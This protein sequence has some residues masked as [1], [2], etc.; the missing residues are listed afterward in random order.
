MP[1][2]LGSLGYVLSFWL[3]IQPIHRHVYSETQHYQDYTSYLSAIEIAMTQDLDFLDGTIFS[4]TEFVLITGKITNH[5][6]PD[7]PVYGEALDIP[8]YVRVRQ[9]YRGY[10][11][12]HAYVYRWD[13]DGYHSMD[14]DSIEFKLFRQKWFRQLCFDHRLMR[15]SRLRAI[16][17]PFI[18]GMKDGNDQIK[19]DVGDFMIPRSRSNQFYDWYDRE[20]GLYPLYIC[21]I[22]FTRP[23]PFIQCDPNAIDFG[24][25]YGVTQNKLP[26]ETLLRKC[27][28]ETYRLQ[29][30]MLKYISIYR[31]SD[32]FWSFYPPQLK[33][34]Y[35]ACKKKHDPGNRFISVADKLSR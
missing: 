7:L 30:D 17:K 6:N 8:Y 26:S 1:C 10:F 21:P 16:F 20:I 4:P 2:T 11:N 25:G 19:A 5:R 13:I 18:T 22:T 27:M 28:Y 32:E 33:L 23:T 14:G 24:V 12:Y 31:D 9:G 35:D 34:E 3:E 15:E 29:G